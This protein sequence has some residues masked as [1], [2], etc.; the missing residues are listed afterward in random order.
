MI[1]IKNMEMPKGCQHCMY[2]RKHLFGNGIDYSYSC[3][4]GATE[5]QMPWIRQM[6]ERA[7]DCPLAEIVTCKD[8]KYIRQNEDNEYYCD[9]SGGY[10]DPDYYCA[11]GERRK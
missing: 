7:S 4:L 11:D 8:C 5:F 3:V 9:L 6:E 10:Y 1:A 2:F